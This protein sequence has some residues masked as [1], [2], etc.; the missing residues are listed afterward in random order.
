M[1]SPIILKNETLDKLESWLRSYLTN[2]Y[3]KSPT[4]ITL[5]HNDVQQT[6][7]NRK[8]LVKKTYKKKGLEDNPII[9]DEDIEFN[10]PYPTKEIT[11]A[12]FRLS[13]IK[14]T[15]L[16]MFYQSDPRSGDGIKYVSKYKECTENIGVHYIVEAQKEFMREYDKII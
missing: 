4:L 16:T 6:S 5:D 1:T 11:K 14:Q 10:N 8:S 15:I 7:A 2:K 9:N 12:F 3:G 13:D